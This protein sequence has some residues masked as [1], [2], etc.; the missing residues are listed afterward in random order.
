[1]NFES[2]KLE[3]RREKKEKKLV[4]V[5]QQEVMTAASEVP[6]AVVRDGILGFSIATNSSRLSDI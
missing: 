2:W 4:K 6:S 1:M 3:N 5:G